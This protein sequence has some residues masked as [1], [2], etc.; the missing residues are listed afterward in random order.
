MLDPGPLLFALAVVFIAG[1][2]QSMTGFGFGLVAIPLLTMFI[3]P[4]LA[5]PIVLVDGMVLNAYILKNAYPAVQPK[6][7]G[8]LTLAGVLGVPI[9]TYVLS[10]FDVGSLRIYIG[11]MTCIAAAFFLSGFRKEVKNERLISAP[12]GFVSGIMSG[13]INMA[14]PPVILFFANQNLPRM[15]FRANIIA[16]FFTL[17][18]VAI[19][20]LI[21]HRI[22][23]MDA[24]TSAVVLFPSL[25]AG[26]FVGGKL[27]AKVDDRI[28][29]NMTLLIVSFAGIVS[30][31]NGLDVI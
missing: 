6:R 8:L 28:V 18:V 4:K 31:L 15:I 22:L 10:H 9:G 1:I 12:V 27:S 14:G 13:S 24:F 21:Y 29:R 26:G 25:I 5:P 19:P 2:T 11:V 17:Q 16:Y 20:L 23:T 3:S 7:I 30:I